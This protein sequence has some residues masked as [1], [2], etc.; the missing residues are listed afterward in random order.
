MAENSRN[1]KHGWSAKYEVN[2]PS[3]DREHREMFV[4]IGELGN[5]LEAGKESA[6]P[7]MVINLFARVSEHFVHEEEI[8]SQTKYEAL[9]A[10]KAEHYHVAC[11]MRDILRNYESGKTTFNDS[12]VSFL[13]DWLKMHIVK[14]DMLYAEHLLLAGVR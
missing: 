8:M 2:I 14:T 6:L 9:E 1:P 7:P 12:V 13:S 3:I 11:E 10:H 4:M 5:T